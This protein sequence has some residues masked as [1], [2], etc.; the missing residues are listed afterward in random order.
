MFST[1]AKIGKVDTEKRGDIRDNCD[2]S[3]FRG[4]LQ[5]K[6]KLHQFD[7]GGSLSGY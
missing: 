5:S 3:T 2:V 7:F 4:L 1:D 6:L